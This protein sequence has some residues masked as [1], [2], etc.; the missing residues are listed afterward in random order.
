MEP[1][2]LHAG[3]RPLLGGW[4]A[5]GRAPTAAWL[6]ELAGALGRPLNAAGR[7]LFFSSAPDDALGY[8]QR[9][10]AT[11]CVA[12]RDFSWHDAFNALV[13]LIFPQTKAAMN[14][15]HCDEMMHP[16]SPGAGRG[17]VRDALTQFDET[18]IVLVSDHPTLLDALRNHHWREALWE[19]RSDMDAAGVFVPGHAL[20]EKVLR[21]YPGLCAKACYVDAAEFGIRAADVTPAQVDAWL[22][23][24]IGRRIWPQSPGDLHPLPVLGLPGMTPENLASAY[25][26]DATQF[27][28][29]PSR[30]RAE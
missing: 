30:R 2:V 3:V 8:E 26:E 4:P 14:R 15:R 27:R 6:D 18:G 12:T 22:A 13:W 16:V 29:L 20:L 5:S 9:I 28:P 19:R 7:P 23:E 10:L 17:P 21:P 11:G 25:F 1:G 24:R